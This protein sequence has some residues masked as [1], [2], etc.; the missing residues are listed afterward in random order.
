MDKYLSPIGWF[1]NEDGWLLPVARVVRNGEEVIVVCFFT[2]YDG[3]VRIS[4]D[5]SHISRK[6]FFGSP[7][8]AFQNMGSSPL[9]Q[10]DVVM[11]LI[12]PIKKITKVSKAGTLTI[13]ENKGIEKE[14]F[15]PAPNNVFFLKLKDAVIE[16]IRK[17]QRRK[18][19][20]R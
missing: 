14:L 2:M 12:R 1:V 13:Y 8:E 19:N 20:G 11:L 4:E 16:V 3:Q 6:N 9:W 10:A 15:A 17:I 7:I 5:R 18:D